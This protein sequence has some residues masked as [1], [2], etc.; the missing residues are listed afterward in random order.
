MAQPEDDPLDL[1]WAYLVIVAAL[2][3]ISSIDVGVMDTWIAGPGRNSTHHSG[4][5]DY[6][7]VS[8]KIMAACGEELQEPNRNM[9]RTGDGALPRRLVFGETTRS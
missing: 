2:T 1:K 8:L 5:A 3:A 4:L 9:R 6:A 7:H